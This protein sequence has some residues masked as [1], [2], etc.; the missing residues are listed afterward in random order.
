M[1][2]INAQ[3]VFLR[4]LFACL[5][6]DQEFYYAALALLSG[7]VTAETPRAR[8]AEVL[9]SHLV[10]MGLDIH[11]GA[12]AVVVFVKEAERNI[13]CGTSPASPSA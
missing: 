3:T 2:M 11:D 4:D 9:Y 1:K 8:I 10:D 5:Q 6:N 13:R 7:E 12:R